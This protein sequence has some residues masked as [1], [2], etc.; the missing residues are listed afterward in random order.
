MN[1]SLRDEDE[2]DREP[3]SS[4]VHFF[5]SLE[6]ITNETNVTKT[7]LDTV[8]PSFRNRSLTQ[9]SPAVKK[10]SSIASGERIC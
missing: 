6:S 1:I 8:I 5:G 7:F 10:M 3:N 2:E 9:L 4:N